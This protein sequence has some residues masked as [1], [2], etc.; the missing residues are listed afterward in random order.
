MEEIFEG[1]EQTGVNEQEVE[2]TPAAEPA[3]DGAEQGENEQ[4][5]AEPV[6]TPDQ[7]AIYAAARRRA[8]AEAARRSQ[9]EMDDFAR[10]VFAGQTNP[11]TGQPIRSKADYD[12]YIGQYRAEQ[13]QQAGISP[14]VLNQMIESNPA[15]QQ[16][17]QMTARLRQED[18]ERMLAEQVS[19]ISKIDPDIKGFA[20]LV[21]K[22]NFAQFDAMVRQG[23]AL[24][25]AYKLANYDQLAQKRAAAAK[26]Q[27]LN[28]VAGK[29]HLS[30][31]RGTNGGEDVVIP[32][33]TEAYYRKWFPDWTQ[34]QMLDDYKKHR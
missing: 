18:G 34:K 31:T 29:G 7:N 19:E 27:T 15:V 3:P 23:Y 4:A 16:A 14:E 9:A 33:E 28:Q 6:Q 24:V 26:Q 5:A 2:E 22:P 11:Y 17:K 10:E 20:D 21:K 25:D 30:V 32:Q 1:V 8:E 12:A 13:M